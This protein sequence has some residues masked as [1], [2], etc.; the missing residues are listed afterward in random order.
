[1]SSG[2]KI[3]L[4]DAVLI[5]KNFL[6]T[7]AGTMDRCEIAGSIRRMCQ[8]VSDVDIVAIPKFKTVAAASLFGDAGC[9]EESR[10]NLLWFAL[11]KLVETRQIVKHAHGASL[12]PRWGETNRSADYKSLC[13]E[14]RSATESNWGSKL[15]I[16]TGPADFSKRLH[17][18]DRTP[19]RTGQ[20][21][22]EDAITAEIRDSKDGSVVEDSWPMWIMK[23]IAECR[24]L[25]NRLRELSAEVE[26][27]D[28]TITAAIRI[29]D[30]KLRAAEER[31]LRAVEAWKRWR[32]S[33][34]AG[35]PYGTGDKEIDVQLMDHA[36]LWYEFNGASDT[37]VA[38]LDARKGRGA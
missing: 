24:S 1:M 23:L 6:T 31:V 7:L 19:E 34:P 5:A 9:H 14:F 17:P 28:D 18:L 33:K 3:P 32:K 29:P 4:A 36:A 11:D 15:A 27:Q 10:Q 25:R 21:N 38:L 26:D 37:Y 20:M 8:L 12:A 13:F 22:I 35:W 30:P 2:T 16:Y